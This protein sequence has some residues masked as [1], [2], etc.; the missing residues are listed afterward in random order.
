MK[1]QYITDQQEYDWLQEELQKAIV[2]HNLSTKQSC[3]RLIAI[4]FDMD[5]IG[6]M[7][8]TAENTED[9]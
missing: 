6:G 5:I 4:H 8:T 7:G 2:S 9:K 3:L 1:K